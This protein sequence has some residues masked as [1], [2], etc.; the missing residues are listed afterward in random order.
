MKLTQ[1]INDAYLSVIHEKL[2]C[3][4]KIDIFLS[5]GARLTHNVQELAGLAL[6]DVS[7]VNSQILCIS[8]ADSH[9]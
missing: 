8:H 2:A 4:C 7:H 6:H 9:L 5:I 1:K 3:M